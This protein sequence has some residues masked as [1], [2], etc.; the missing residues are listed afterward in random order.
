MK[1]NFELEIVINDIATTVP[2]IAYPIPAGNVINFV[3]KLLFLRL[4]KVNI[5]EKNNVNAAT[6]IP[7]LRVLKVKYNNSVVNPFFN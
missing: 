1:W 2:G 6:I 3:I 4:A 7:R 5:K